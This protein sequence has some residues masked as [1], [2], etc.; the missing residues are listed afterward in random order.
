MSAAGALGSTVFVGE[1]D[2][3][4]MGAGVLGR[5]IAPP[6]QFPRRGVVGTYAGGGVLGPGE[7]LNLG[8]GVRRRYSTLR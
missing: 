5:S 7:E 8:G 4:S 2:D 1:G 3:P 6:R